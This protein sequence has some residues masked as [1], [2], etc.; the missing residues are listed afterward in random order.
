MAKVFWEAYRHWQ[1]DC[2]QEFLEEFGN[3]Q[4]GGPRYHPYMDPPEGA[5]DEA[6]LIEFGEDGAAYPHGIGG[7]AY[8]PNAVT[9]WDKSP[10]Y[11]E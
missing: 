3:T 10:H 1:D 5:D 8:I 6:W 4:V 11:V 9:P 2:L 7:I